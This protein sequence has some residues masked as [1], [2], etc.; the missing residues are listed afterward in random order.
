MDENDKFHSLVYR[1]N[2]E[3]QRAAVEIQILATKTKDLTHHNS[4]LVYHNTDLA[5][6]NGDLAKEVVALKQE[7]AGSVGVRGQGCVAQDRT[8]EV[9]ELQAKFELLEQMYLPVHTENELR[10][11]MLVDTRK[12]ALEISRSRLDLKLPTKRMGELDNVRLNGL[13]VSTEELSLL[14][15]VVTDPNFH[16]W[17]VQHQRDGGADSVETVVNWDDEKLKAMARK[18]DRCSG[19]RGQKVVQEVL[20]CNQELQRWNPSGGYCVVIPYHHGEGR[21]LTPQELLKLAVGIDV[22]G[23]RQHMSHRPGAGVDSRIGSGGGVGMGA[24]GHGRG[25][26]DR[27]MREHGAGGWSHVSTGQQQ[28]STQDPQHTARASGW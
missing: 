4:E 3:A 20:R 16:P 26:L 6:R 25:L 9:E 24:H 10:K 23:C 5:Q 15:G 28:H 11:Q 8:V 7:Q 21:E 14:Q 27:N 19:G 12:A 1:A 18:F 2:A 22:P 13:G 17:R